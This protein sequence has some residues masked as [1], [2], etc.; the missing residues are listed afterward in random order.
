MIKLLILSIFITFSCFSHA[1]TNL[2]ELEKLINTCEVLELDDY[3]YN[4]Q[5]NYYKPEIVNDQLEKLF[6]I[7][8]SLSRDLTEACLSHKNPKLRAIGLISLYKFN[9]FTDLNIYHD[10]LTDTTYCFKTNPFR[11]LKFYSGGPE[12]SIKLPDN[13]TV[14]KEIEKA[15]P[16]RVSDIAHSFLYF[17]ATTAGYSEKNINWRDYLDKCKDLNFTS[18]FLKLLLLKATGG[19]SPLEPGRR[20]YIDSLKAFIEKVEDVELRTIYKIYLNEY[21]GSYANKGILYDDSQLISEFVSLK[22]ETI[23]SILNRTLK[24]NDI[25]LLQNNVPKNSTSSYRA[26]CNWILLHVHLVFDKEDI[27]FLLYRAKYETD[28]IR[29]TNLKTPTW[30][31]A[32][33]RIDTINASKYIKFGLEVLKES[34]YIYDHSFLYSQLWYLAGERESTIILD[35]FYETFYP[36]QSYSAFSFINSIDFTLLRQIVFDKRFNTKITHDDLLSIAYFLN[37]KTD[38]NIISEEYTINIWEY[39]KRFKR[40]TRKDLLKRVA[41]LKNEI[42]KQLVQLQ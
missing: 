24:V 22:K 1:Q 29:D 16:Y 34:Y 2:T 10:F 11:D 6:K 3:F 4:R 39:N 7:I 5:I 30:Y 35:W 42:K 18:G 21:T 31:V 32:C 13:R 36:K 19:I 25:D 28:S 20:I 15:K 40:K 33:G 27:D 38:K 41:I 17:Y 37:S 9:K 12:N 8:A 23:K 26:M 14:I